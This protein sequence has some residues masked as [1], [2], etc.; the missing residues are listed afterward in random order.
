M[1]SYSQSFFKASTNL[2]EF[3]SPCELVEALKIGCEYDWIIRSF[4]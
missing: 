1:Q 3:R 2:H 4:L